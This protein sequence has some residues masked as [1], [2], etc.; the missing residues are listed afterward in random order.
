MQ[1][2]V[3]ILFL[4]LSYILTR[5][6]CVSITKK[7][8]WRV[9]LRFTLC[10]IKFDK[11]INKRDRKKSK[12]NNADNRLRRKIVLHRV[13]EGLRHAEL[14]VRRL[15][16]PIYFPYTDPARACLLQYRYHAIIS[17]V[18]S[19]LKSKAKS[20]TVKD[21]AITLCSDL[22]P[23]FLDVRIKARLFHIISTLALIWHDE[24]KM[25]RDFICRKIR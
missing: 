6:V 5:K 19:F 2:T 24:K 16:V 21:N 1:I 15:S 20:L 12:G 23:N 13:F 17:T 8:N 18:L 14:E 9:E 10:K 4:F 22:P 11:L 7:D 25:K 3:F